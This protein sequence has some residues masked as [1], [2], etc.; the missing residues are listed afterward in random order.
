MA[1]DSPGERPHPASLIQQRIGLRRE[2]AVALLYVVLGALGAVVGIGLISV[3][4]SKWSGWA[5]SIAWLLLA[6]VGARKLF[7]YRKRLAAFED[8]NGVGAGQQ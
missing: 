3:E 1:A 7:R 4:P 2:R 6:G 5:L 8:L